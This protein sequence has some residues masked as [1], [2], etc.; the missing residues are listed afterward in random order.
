MNGFF[1]IDAASVQVDGERKSW[2]Q[3]FPAAGEIK[4]RDGR[5][6]RLSDPNA[7]IAATR[8]QHGKKPIMVDYDHQL[9]HAA[10]N[11]QPAPAAGWITDLE[12]RKD[13]IWGLIEWTAK[14]AAHLAAREYRYISPYFYSHRETGEISRIVNAG[15]TNDPALEMAALANTQRENMREIEGELRSLLNL[16]ADAPGDAILEAVRGLSS[17][18]SAAASARPDRFVPI[19][20]FEEVTAELNRNS[21]GMSLEAASMAVDREIASGRLIPAMRDWALDLCKANKPAFDGF[22]ERTSGGLQHL[23]TRHGPTGRPPGSAA[24]VTGVEAEIARNLGHTP[25]E[26]KAGK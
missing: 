8:A 17:T 11:G 5:K 15:L 9:V 18:A 24:S 12:A 23:F 14:A 20:L 10:K 4:A 19:E 26:M 1:D 13:G 6:W 2:V 7:V 21:Q 16:A 22:V 25:E 3:L